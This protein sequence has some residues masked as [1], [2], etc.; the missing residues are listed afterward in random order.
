[1]NNE[2]TNFHVF[3]PHSIYKHSYYMQDEE[4]A[5][6]QVSMLLFVALTCGLG[7]FLFTKLFG[8]QV[9]TGKL[10]LNCA[11]KMKL[12]VNLVYHTLKNLTAY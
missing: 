1:M 11:N 7:M 5:Q 6:H 9:L 3:S 10:K 12:T 2:R 8:T 4:L